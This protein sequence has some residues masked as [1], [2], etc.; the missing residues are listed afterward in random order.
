[1]TAITVTTRLSPAGRL[2][3]LGLAVAVAGIIIRF[4]RRRGRD[5]CGHRF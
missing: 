3:A 1:M 2:N 5:D 4:D